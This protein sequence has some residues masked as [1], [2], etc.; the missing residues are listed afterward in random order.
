MS[1]EEEL[2]IYQEKAIR[3]YVLKL[4]VIPPIF[5]AIIAGVIGWSLHTATDNTVQE[6]KN[7]MSQSYIAEYKSFLVEAQSL[8]TDALTARTEAQNVTAEAKKLLAEVEE[9]RGNINLVSSL[10]GVHDLPEGVAEK[11]RKNPSFMER[12]GIFKLDDHPVDPLRVEKQLTLSPGENLIHDFTFTAPRD[13]KLLVIASCEGITESHISEDVSKGIGGAAWGSIFLKDSNGY[14]ESLHR[15]FGARHHCGPG[16]ITF[17]AT[18]THVFPTRKGETN[19]Y[20]FMAFKEDGASRD[21]YIN[22]PT[23]QS[24]FVSQ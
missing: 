19:R 20:Q 5:V 3:A 1:D 12:L 6:K 14:S 21:I 15:R 23:V 17:P 4:C 7:E 9:A 16:P 11:L 13:G 24:I 10:K 8:K 2:T 18:I 22:R